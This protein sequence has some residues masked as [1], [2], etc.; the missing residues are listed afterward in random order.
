MSPVAAKF[1]QNAII[2]FPGA[3]L[4]LL[5]LLVLLLLLHSTL[6]L[7]TFLELGGQFKSRN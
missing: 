7:P 2:A 6:F 1:S 4:L 5:L 3:I